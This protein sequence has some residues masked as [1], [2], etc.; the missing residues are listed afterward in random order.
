MSGPMGAAPEIRAATPPQLRW[1]LP[2]IILSALIFGAA[3]G[4]AAWI[5]SGEPQ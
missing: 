5:L 1:S 3:T 2:R 4:L